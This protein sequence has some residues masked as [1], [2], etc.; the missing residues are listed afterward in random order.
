MIISIK[1]S[2]KNGIQVNF[3]IKKKWVEAYAHQ[4][5]RNWEIL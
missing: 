5:G 2:I 4:I 3:I 1:S